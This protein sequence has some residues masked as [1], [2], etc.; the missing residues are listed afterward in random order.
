[1]FSAEVDLIVSIVTGLALVAVIFGTFARNKWGINAVPSACPSCHGKLPRF[2]KPASLKQAL[3][4][5]TTCPSCHREI[6]KWGREV[7]A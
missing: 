7:S 3:W 6:D 4:G 1:M 2:R 5:G